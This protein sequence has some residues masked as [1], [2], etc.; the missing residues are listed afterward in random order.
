MGFAARQQNARTVG[1]K[2]ARV[3]SQAERP[4]AV[5]IS[6]LTFQTAVIKDINDYAASVRG[7]YEGYRTFSIPE[8]VGGRFSVLSPVGLVP[9]A[10]IGIDTR[11][12]ARGAMQMTHLCWP[13]RAAGSYGLP[14]LFRQWPRL[15]TSEKSRQA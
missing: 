5:G 13:L 14:S 8:N 4:G 7:S 6:G 2:G 9:S 11:K 15:R 12:L 1:S 10:L 3:L